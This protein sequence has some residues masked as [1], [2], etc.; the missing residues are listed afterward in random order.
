M[1]EETGKT[2]T[3]RIPDEMFIDLEDV[4]QKEDRSKGA[5]IRQ[6]LEKELSIRLGFTVKQPI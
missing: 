3:F 4:A 5:V 1:V 2:F 6:I